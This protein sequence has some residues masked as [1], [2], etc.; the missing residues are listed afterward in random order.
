M[1][2][3]V[4]RAEAF[5]RLH[6]PGDPV[7][8]FNA[9]DAGSAQAIAKAGARAIGTG[10]WSVAAAHGYADG[11]KMPLALAIANL[12]RIVA[13]VDLPVTIDLEGGYGPRADDVASSVTLAIR[14]G[15]VGINLED[16]YAD[17]HGI[18]DIG[19]MV[20]RIRAARA[21]A[22]RSGVPLFINARTDFFLQTDPARHDASL[23]AAAKE[24]A[25]AYAAAGA[26][27]LFVPCIHKAE[28][29]REVCAATT[30]PV[31]VMMMP[32]LPSRAELA[33]L[34]VARISHGPGP[35]RAAMQF[36]EQA[37]RDAIHG[38]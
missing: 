7:V 23:V 29:I 33:R 14:A 5:R 12:E 16:G 1:T 30:L 34:G 10:S 20:E 15:A 36:L 21:A 9:W 11:E 4:A 6:V 35:Y 25:A 32:T 28:H 27:G 2:D 3:Q 26:N 31:N 8:I 19:D 24:R 22:D 17:E 18:R 13:A 38:Q 37:A